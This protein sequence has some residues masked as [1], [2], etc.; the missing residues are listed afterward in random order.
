MRLPIGAFSACGLSFRSEVTMRS[1]FQH[2]Q[3]IGRQIFRLLLIVSLWRGPMP[4]LHDH[5][6]LAEGAG[7]SRHLLLYHSGPRQDSPASDRSVQTERMHWHFARIRDVLDPNAP[8]EGSGHD[9][10]CGFSPS[11]NGLRSGACWSSTELPDCGLSV[12]QSAVLPHGIQFAGLRTCGLSGG[13]RGTIAHLSM[14]RTVCLQSM[15]F[16]L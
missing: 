2:S 6:L 5:A 15:S 10:I 9:D 1:L 4:V 13:Q 11:V 12:L 3:S 16:L 7:L 14:G 8:P